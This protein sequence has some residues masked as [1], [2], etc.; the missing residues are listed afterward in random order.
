MNDSPASLFVAFY[1]D[2]LLYLTRLNDLEAVGVLI[3]LSKRANRFGGCDPGDSDLSALS[4]HRRDAIPAIV[5]RLQCIDYLHIIET[6]VPYRLK[7][8]RGYQV[9]PYVLRLGIDNQASAIAEWQ[10]FKS[11]TKLDNEK[12]TTSITFPSS[13][14]Q[15]DQNQNQSQNQLQNQSHN[16][17]P[18]NQLQTSASGADQSE[19][20][21]EREGQTPKLAQEQGE[22]RTELESLPN[23]QAVQG[24]A[25]PPIDAPPQWEP[26]K[27]THYKRALADQNDENLALDIVSLAGDMSRENARMLVDTY[28]WDWCMWVMSIYRK[29]SYSVEHPAR[30]IRAMLRKTTTELRQR[31]G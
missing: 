18:T 5:G 16:Q 2:A 10:R 7:P 8:L 27:L 11:Q 26:K 25:P 15:P 21:S 23:G 28:G 24:S 31:E 17:L 22:A 19:K 9:S 29:E 3:A 1:P 6:P 4:G 30:W 12:Q 20:P 13:D 14:Q